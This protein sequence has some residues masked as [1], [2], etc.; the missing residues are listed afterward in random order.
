MTAKKLYLKRTLLCVIT[1]LLVCFI[2]I[3][4]AL[5]ADTSSKGSMSVTD[6]LNSFLSFLRISLVLS[7]NFVRKLAHFVEYF[8]LGAFMF[9]AFRSFDVRKTYC[10]FL[11][12]LI[13]FL[14][15]SVDETIQ[16]FSYGR[17]GQISD[18]LLDFTGVTI[19]VLI[20]AVLKNIFTK[21][22]DKEVLN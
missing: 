1:F 22:K 19:A 4:S 21:K 5:P 12:P 11:V 14:V 16:L 15:A 18:V 9:S 17:S 2:F 7:E 6:I 20:S 13:G 3:N 10:V 8:T